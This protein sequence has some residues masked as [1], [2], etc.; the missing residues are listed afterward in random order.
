MVTGEKMCPSGGSVAVHDGVCGEEREQ[1]GSV[2]AVCV[3]SQDDALRLYKEGIWSAS[4]YEEWACF[5]M[6]RPVAPFCDF[7]RYTKCC[8]IEVH[9]GTV[10]AARPK[11]ASATPLYKKRKRVLPQKQQVSCAG[12]EQDFA[13]FFEFLASQTIP[14]VVVKGRVRGASQP[15]GG[16][17]SISGAAGAVRSRPVQS[18]DEATAD[19]MPAPCLPRV[20]RKDVR[21][22]ARRRHLAS[23]K[24]RLL[25]EEEQYE[26]QMMQNEHAARLAEVRKV[27]EGLPACR[28][29]PRW[30]GRRSVSEGSPAACAEEPVVPYVKD[31][32]HD[33]ATQ[34]RRNRRNFMKTFGRRMQAKPVCDPPSKRFAV[35]DE[36]NLGVSDSLCV[37]EQRAYR[38]RDSEG[39]VVK[40]LFRAPPGIQSLGF[41]RDAGS[42]LGCWN[43]KCLMN[44][45]LQC[46]PAEVR[47]SMRSHF[48]EHC[49]NNMPSGACGGAVERANLEAVVAA[50][51]MHDLRVCVC[52][53]C[54]QC[55]RF[56]PRCCTVV[57]LSWLTCWSCGW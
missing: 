39:R 40:G 1:S 37:E 3:S 27:T 34:Q 21:K 44:A 57:Q 32:G 23:L 16:E 12:S 55:E 18:Q 19:A 47:A 36:M 30:S 45:V 42:K 13:E 11:S 43:E 53:G 46:A 20:K 54:F 50:L 41:V 31:A 24:P 22:E 2:S 48:L 25:G 51:E 52:L 6:S 17:A 26:L 7:K 10:S 49:A 38:V 56:R 15:A 28:T 33:F 4:D 14:V 9:A 35:Y 5:A 29:V 8:K